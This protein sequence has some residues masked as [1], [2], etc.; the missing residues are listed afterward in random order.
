MIK[1]YNIEGFKVTEEYVTNLVLKYG[2][3]SAICRLRQRINNHKKY[4][5]IH[6]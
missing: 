4:N 3:S 1:I 5:K 2:L 6:K